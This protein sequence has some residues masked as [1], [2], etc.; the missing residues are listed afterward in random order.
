M[1]LPL[2]EESPLRRKFRGPFRD[3]GF[4]PLHRIFVGR[5]ADVARAVVVVVR[6]HAAD[7][8]V[9]HDA[10]G[11]VVLISFLLPIL[12]DLSQALALVVQRDELLDRKSTRLNSSHLVI[13]Y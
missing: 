6:E 10:R 13:S 11:P 8:A 7:L 3:D 9:L 12:L 2:H 1:W 5:P 4:E